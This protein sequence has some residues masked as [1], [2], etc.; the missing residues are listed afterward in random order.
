MQKYMFI[1]EVI[2]SEDVV[3]AYLNMQ[4]YGETEQLHRC[5]QQ[6]WQKQNSLKSRFSHKYWMIESSDKKQ[7]SDPWVGTFRGLRW[8]QIYVFVYNLKIMTTN[9]T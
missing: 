7:V 9:L 1:E 6:C 5:L 3:N 4:I 8:S 2:G